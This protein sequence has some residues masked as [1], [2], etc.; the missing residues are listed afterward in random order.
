MSFME[1]ISLDFSS[2]DPEQM[3]DDTVSSKSVLYWAPIWQHARRT[4]YFYLS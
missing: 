3:D 1:N 4:N 2:G